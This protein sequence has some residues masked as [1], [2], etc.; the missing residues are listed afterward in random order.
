[1]SI[2]DFLTPEEIKTLA[3]LPRGEGPGA[4][5]PIPPG[6]PSRV[7]ENMFSV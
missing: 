6:P 7:L 5:S 1:V 2:Q 3:P 4:A